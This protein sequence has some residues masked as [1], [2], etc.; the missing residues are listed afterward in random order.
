[1]IKPSPQHILVVDDDAALRLLTRSALEQAGFTVTEAADG[2]AAVE[3]VKVNRP[4]LILM[5]VEM[6]RMDG[7]AACRAIRGLPMGNELPIIMVT[8][9][10]DLESINRAY[11]MGATD[12][13]SKP[14]NWP[15]LGH[16]VRYIMRTSMISTGLRDSEARN[17]AFLEAI[18]DMIFVVDKNGRFFDHRGGGENRLLPHSDVTNRTIF[19]ALPSSVAEH[20]QRLINRVLASRKT[21]TAEFHLRG[22]EG[23]RFF[24]IRMVVYIEDHVLAIVRDITDQKV[25][26]AKI[27]RLAFFDTLTG[28]PNRTSFLRRLAG[29]VKLAD[30]NDKRLG[31]LYIDLDDFKRI[32]DTLGHSVGDE[33]LKTVAKRLDQCVRADDYVARFGRGASHLQLA[34]LGGD[35]FTIMLRD[36]ESADEA[37]GI[38]ER[39]T[40]LLRKP[41]NHHG[42]EF[43]ITPSIGIAIYP[44]DGNDIETLVKNAD[45]AMYQAKA[46]GRNSHRFYSGTMS[47]R[48]LERLDLEHSLRRALA[49]DDLELHY[50]PK[51]DLRSGEIIGVEALLRWTHPDRGPISPAKFIPLAEETGMIVPLG[52]WVLSQACRQIKAWSRS[53]VGELPVAINLSSQQFYF[54]DVHETIMK[55]LFESGVKPRLLELELTESILMRDVDET[56]ASLTRLKKSGLSLAVDDFGTGYSSLSYLKRFPLDALKIDRSFVM[57]LQ[58]NSDDAAICSAII[59]LAHSLGLSVIAEGVET[60]EQLAF[61]RERSCDVIQGYFFARPQSAVDVSRFILEHR[62]QTTRDATS[63]DAG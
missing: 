52:E 26:D 62:A 17:R 41:V 9:R 18:P 40:T 32:N 36:L 2:A 37:T 51:L 49:D 1:M 13:I 28:L 15:L 60:E 55:A 6:P 39:I 8:G 34:R 63:E 20:W 31:I 3:A 23:D 19:D 11:E 4:A 53:S 30:Q 29:A 48:S 10:E 22:E 44:D 16:R 12:F 21:E 38:A 58:E 33:L 27:Q 59:A 45:V 57:E 50:Q 35:E 47:V 5:D 54:S 46:S 43:V 56:V 42:H 14:I 61:L 7:F 24:E 25:A